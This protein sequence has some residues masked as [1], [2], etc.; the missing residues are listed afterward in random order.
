MWKIFYYQGI[1]GSIV[2]MRRRP[3]AAGNWKN[4]KE[5]GLARFLKVMGDDHPV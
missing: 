2:E 4:K 3:P 5:T 1:A